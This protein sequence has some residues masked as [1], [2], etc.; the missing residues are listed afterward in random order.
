M[1]NQNN[2][3]CLLPFGA[4]FPLPSNEMVLTF[5]QLSTM[6]GATGIISVPLKVNAGDDFAIFAGEWVTFL[7]RM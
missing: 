7:Q 3:P 2:F 1:K 6:K 4:N 5:H